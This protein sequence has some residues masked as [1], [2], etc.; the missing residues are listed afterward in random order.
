VPYPDSADPEVRLQRQSHSLRAGETPLG[1]FCFGI[2]ERL[3]V[4]NNSAERAARGIRFPFA[5]CDPAEQGGVVSEVSAAQ[6]PD[7]GSEVISRQ[8]EQF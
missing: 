6:T 1:Q 8:S 2:E 4:S 3:R 5:D 7:H